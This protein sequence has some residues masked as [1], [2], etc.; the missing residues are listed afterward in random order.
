M[1]S[2]QNCCVNVNKVRL[3]YGPSFWFVIR[4]HQEVCVCVCRNISLHLAFI[5]PAPCPPQLTHAHRKT[6]ELVW[7]VTAHSLLVLMHWLVWLNDCAGYNVSKKRRARGVIGNKHR[8]TREEA[9]KWFQQKVGAR[10]V[11]YSV[12]QLTTLSHSYLGFNVY[13]VVWVVW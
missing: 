1:P 8:V 7:H 6:A 4:V 10:D 3:T 9:M 5:P 11:C 2:S 12:I 13:S